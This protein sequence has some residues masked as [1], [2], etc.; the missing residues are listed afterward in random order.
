MKFKYLREAPRKIESFKAAGTTKRLENLEFLKQDW[1]DFAAYA[2]SKEKSRVIQSKITEYKKAAFEI[3][4]ELLGNEEVKELGNLWKQVTEFFVKEDIIKED[5]IKSIVDT[6]NS[7]PILSLADRVDVLESLIPKM[8]PEILSTSNNYG[9]TVLHFVVQQYG[10]KKAELLIAKMEPKALN[11][12]NYDRYTALHLALQAGNDKIA[13]L[14]IAKMSPEAISASD[15]HNSTA[16]HYAAEKGY[17]KIAELL[18]AKM[19]PEAISASDNHNATALHLAAERGYDKIAELLIAKM[20][21]ETSIINANDLNYTLKLVVEINA[22]KIAGLL[23]KKIPE[24]ISAYYGSAY[25]Y[26]ESIKTILAKPDEYPSS[27]EKAKKQAQDI[28]LSGSWDKNAELG[29]TFSSLKKSIRGLKEAQEVFNNYVQENDSPDN[30]L[31]EKINDIKLV[32]ELIGR[33]LYRNNPLFEAPQVISIKFSE[34]FNKLKEDNGVGLSVEELNSLVYLTTL[35]PQDKPSF[36][37]TEEHIVS[38]KAKPLL[39]KYLKVLES[40]SVPKEICGRINEFLSSSLNKNLEKLGLFKLLI[41]ST[42][43]KNDRLTL[44]QE[45]IDTTDAVTILREDINKGEY[46]LFQP[47]N[48]PL[49]IELTDE[50]INSIQNN[51]SNLS[52]NDESDFSIIE[53]SSNTEHLPIIH[54]SSKE[55]ILEETLRK[56]LTILLPFIIW[57]IINGY[58]E[59]STI[60]SLAFNECRRLFEE[61]HNDKLIRISLKYNLNEFLPVNEQDKSFK[62]KIIETFNLIDYELVAEIISHNDLENLAKILKYHITGVQVGESHLTLLHIACSA[63]IVEV[64]DYL[65]K[66]SQIDITSKSPAGTPLEIAAHEAVLRED[67]DLKL[68]KN[69]LQEASRQRQ[70]SNEELFHVNRILHCGPTILEKNFAEFV[71]EGLHEEGIDLDDDYRSYILGNASS[72]EYEDA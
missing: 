28:I 58:V 17:N 41:G 71:N 12:S 47:Y 56:E 9:S 44:L 36:I 37:L 43:L 69:M 54:L 13:E 39:Y 46:P 16:L 10:N 42:P 63:Y 50:H 45:D 51:Y 64:V 11:V 2:Y 65:L 70:I 34:Y 7:F 53:S 25:G 66:N 49:V 38:D 61:G 40:F 22:N 6:N 31:I 30:P 35:D 21:P 62:N 1:L 14:L 19:F 15:K 52:S 18:I 4:E 33:V 59:V 57:E 26:Y 60:N 48:A 72:S 5:I 8:P 27:I 32:A 20:T 3:E 67:V 68:I 29:V 55:G 24:I 23:I